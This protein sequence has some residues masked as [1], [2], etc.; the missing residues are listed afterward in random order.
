MNAPLL[1]VALGLVCLPILGV[2]AHAQA[3][4]TWVSG[5]GDDANPCSR[6]AP[7]KTFPGAIS[8]T[9]TSGIINC[10]DS[11]GFGTVT[12]TK[13]ITI[14]CRPFL[15]GVLAAGIPNGI[16]V[17]GNGS[18]I[19]VR[20]VGLDIEGAAS[21]TNGVNFINGGELTIEDC[22]I[23]GFTG[24]GI[25]FAPPNGTNAELHV[26]NTTASD[27]GSGVFVQPVGNGIAHVDLTRVQLLG[28]GNGLRV[29]GTNG[30]TGAARVSVRDSVAAGNTTGFAVVSSGAFSRITISNSNAAHNVTGLQADQAQAA[31]ILT[32][33]TSTA[34]NTGIS[35]TNGAQ[36]F[37]YTNNFING[38]VSVDGVPTATLTPH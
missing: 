13:S 37:S 31:L 36:S 16:V 11:G 35:T 14:D 30:N 20:L 29:D 34:N 32:G 33:V 8:K 38:N 26:V 25:A 27:N 3:T 6:T 2:P 19:V 17:N 28:N 22:K 23:Y 18:N 5:V 12:I 4:R 21:G 10:I 1:V 7:C 24:N 15:G 9:A